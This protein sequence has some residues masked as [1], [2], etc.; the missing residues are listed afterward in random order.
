MSKEIVLKLQKIEILMGR[1]M[2]RL[3]AV[4]QIG[5]IE[6]TYYRWRKQ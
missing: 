4:R 5:V 1:G 2:S 3:D 6:R